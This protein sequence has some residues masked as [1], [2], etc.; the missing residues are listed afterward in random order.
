MFPVR[1]TALVGL[2]LSVLRPLPLCP[3]IIDLLAFLRGTVPSVAMNI[4]GIIRCAVSVARIGF[5]F[6]MDTLRFCLWILRSR[7]AQA[8]EILILRKQ[9]ALCKE[10]EVPFSRATD[11]ARLALVFLSKLTPRWREC[12]FI[13]KP[14]TLLRW[15][16]DAARLVWR[17]RCRGGG[18]PSLPFDT[19]TLIRRLARENPR[20]GE[21]RIQS[22]L[23][24]KF[25]IVVSA[26][27]VRKYMPKI[28]RSPRGDQ[29]WSIFVRNHAKVM[30]ACDFLTVWTVGFSTLYVFVV[31]EIGSRK[32]LHFNVTS[33]PS[34]C[35]TE[36]QLRQA[37]PYDH[38]YRYL[39]HDR[40]RIFS[41]D[42]DRSLKNM[43]VKVLKT[44]VMSPLANSFCER[45][46]GT[47]RR[48][49][50]DFLI[51]LGEKHLRI[52]LTEWVEHYNRGR[53]H[54][55]LG[56]GIPDPPEGFPAP[57]A[58]NRHEIP[59]G[60]RVVA[61]PILGGLHHEYRIEKIAA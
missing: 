47:I 23:L 4:S 1:V 13:V 27:T 28:E 8:A 21:E 53:P 31:M 50:L 5:G 42:L 30:M 41:K 55:S 54:S 49:C 35:W 18:R 43:G 37:I 14:G 40:D 48:E 59:E 29:R 19:R 36:Q 38:G 60:H 44:P 12:L 26:R 10:R 17:R 56:P 32:I 7:A 11:P 22:E 51:P 58:E 34:A 9:V 15:H 2:S 25:G 46:N 20:W 45:L 33:N 6:V 57:L 16:R 3:A 52:L 39:I 24:T 61:K